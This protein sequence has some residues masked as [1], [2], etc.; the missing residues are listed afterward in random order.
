MCVTFLIE[1]QNVQN[2]GPCN[3]HIFLVFMVKECINYKG[4]CLEA[5]FN[6]ISFI[7]TLSPYAI[8]VFFSKYMVQTQIHTFKHTYSLAMSTHT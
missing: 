6:N 5:G 1:I 7:L 8:P 3:I 2:K 4:C